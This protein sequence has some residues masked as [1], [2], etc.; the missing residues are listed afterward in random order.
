MLIRN[1]AIIGNQSITKFLINY[2]KKRKVNIKYLITLK[3]KIKFNI[4]DP[5]EF[6]N[7]DKKK[8]IFV[9][10]YNLKSSKD[11]IKLKKLKIDFLL[12]FGWSRLIPE[13]LLKHIKIST[14]GVHAG[15]FNPPR[16]RGRAVFNWSLIGSY[17]KMI[18]YIMELKKGID[19]GDI[20]IK[21]K[22][23]IS[24]LDDI[25][26]LYS[27]NAIIS[28]NMFFKVIK[29]WRYFN[30]NRYKQNN[31]NSS[32]F[33]KRNPEDAYINW[34]HSAEQIFNLVIA[35][36]DPYPGAF[37]YLNDKKIYIEKVVPFDINFKGKFKNGEVVI[38]F[39][40]EKFVVKCKNSFLLVQKIKVDK[41]I[42]LKEN[43]IL[44]SSNVKLFNFKKI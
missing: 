33:P 16:S 3:N 40:N 22:Q 24:I 44:K 39:S 6:E 34:H 42:N 2:L 12:V 15:I 19:D 28:S 20:F 8:K 11:F 23:K 43:Q 35:V 25:D 14:L 21:K 32:F 36:K 13:W 10:S 29:K 27:K 18:F 9:E 7:I 38:K 37:T 5:V 17:N 30:K 31:Y 26:S 1:I 41:K 4:T